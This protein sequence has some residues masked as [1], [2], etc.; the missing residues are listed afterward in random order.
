[1]TFYGSLVAY[2][3]SLVASMFLLFRVIGLIDC[4]L[5]G[6]N[7]AT[8]ETEA[9]M[10]ASVDAR[11]WRVL[12]GGGD[13]GCL[14]HIA[15]RRGMVRALEILVE[16]GAD[17]RA[18]DS[19]G[20][21]PLEIVRQAGMSEASAY[22]ETA[23]LKRETVCGLTVSPRR[24]A[25]SVGRIW[26]KWRG[27]RR[28]SPLLEEKRSDIFPGVVGDAIEYSIAGRRS[29]AHFSESSG[30]GNGNNLDVRT[31][32]I[33]K[34]VL[35]QLVPLGRKRNSEGASR[36]WGTGA[37]PGRAARDG[38][39][40]FTVEDPDIK[41][42]S[43]DVNT[44]VH[45]SSKKEKNS[46]SRQAVGVDETRD[47][48]RTAPGQS[49][50]VVG[51]TNGSNC[52]THEV[53]RKGDVTRRH[54]EGVESLTTHD[55]DNEV[56][57]G[58]GKPMGWRRCKESCNGKAGSGVLSEIG[59]AVHWEAQWVSVQNLSCWKR[60]RAEKID[61]EPTS[62]AI[63][64]VV[65]ESPIMGATRAAATCTT[66]DKSRRS[67]TGPETL[68]VDGSI[69]SP[70]EAESQSWMENKANEY[71]EKRENTCLFARVISRRRQRSTIRKISGTWS[72]RQSSDSGNPAGGFPGA[73][74]AAAA[75]S[76][77]QSVLNISWGLRR[78]R[79][80]STPRERRAAWKTLRETSPFHIPPMY[81][82]PF[83]DL[84]ALGEIPKRTGDRFWGHAGRRPVP[85]WELPELTSG[86][87]GE[88]GP[89]VAYVS[90]RWLEPDF[91]NPDDHTKARF[92]QAR[93]K[94]G[95]LGTRALVCLNVDL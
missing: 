34:S 83:V 30:G 95:E 37:A 35:G 13:I 52:L 15:A 68:R 89:L 53:I 2:G 40:G 39:G 73:F 14:S 76:P 75:C 10:E 38:N 93:G 46:L 45:R 24:G 26:R 27:G 54:E 71:P 47:K 7:T 77:T 60:G 1:M 58:K 62:S 16:H 20:K 85:C 59:Q 33:L 67:V 61:V 29:V 82:L 50:A 81:L 79:P 55:I 41:T 66:R 22:L 28:V 21:T 74:A 12:G 36:E 43:M 19:T 69:V 64:S 5:Y 88:G 57:L 94:L 70:T 80:L 17:P 44:P 11:S 48:A 63:T 91:K 49:D 86:S 18:V 90:H 4:A 6:H 51:G 31:R 3:I 92:Y 84:V 42:P 8:K 32:G 87:N 9:V 65:D 56:V 25:S 23:V 78:L 72:K